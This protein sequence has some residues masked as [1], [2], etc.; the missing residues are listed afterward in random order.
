MKTRACVLYGK[1]DVRIETREIGDVGPKQVRVR[2]GAG[3][4]CGSDI[5][6]FRDGGIGTIQVSEPIILGHE[7]A[8]TVEAVG[9]EVANVKPGSRVALCPSLPCGHCRF[10][11]IGQ[12]QHCLEMQFFGSAMRKPHC[13]GGFRDEII[14]ED[15][16]CEPVGDIGLDEAACAEPLAVGLH[17]INNAGSVF[18]KRVLVMG[19]GPIGAL[20]VGAAKLAGAEEV[21]AVD[22]ADAPLKAA[23]KMGAMTTVNALAEPDRL[24]LRYSGDKGY[25]DVGFECTGVGVAL[26][27]MFPVVKP[28]GVI[29]AVGV[30]SGAHI[31]F[32]AL[33]GKEL[34]LAGTH[35][36]HAE[37]PI[38]ARLIAERRIDVRPIISATLPMDRI[39]EAFDVVRDR[40]LQMKVQLSFAT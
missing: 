31:P 2:I 21:V 25:F 12:Q 40:S 39:R 23:I 5:H 13:N 14:V 22:L 4:L 11:Q 9:G 18:G 29:V 34:H 27:N 36:F 19:A 15:F 8:G 26:G 10:C 6:Y 1:G 37:Y 35:R 38:A 20:L 24:G 28:R 33:V 30:S 16:Q 3:G 17:A 32:N 7:V